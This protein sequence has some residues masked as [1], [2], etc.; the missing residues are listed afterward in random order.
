MYPFQ[1][2][3]MLTKVAVA[4][5]ETV[6]SLPQTFIGRFPFVKMLYYIPESLQLLIFTE[7][8]PLLIKIRTDTE[9]RA[10][11]NRCYER[12]V[13]KQV[14]NIRTPFTRRPTLEQTK[15]PTLPLARGIISPIEGEG[16]GRGGGTGGK[17]GQD[18]RRFAKVF[19]I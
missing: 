19:N 10:Y 1:D 2:T 6:K 18:E 14:K 7:N 11:R 4:I 9:M 12:Y 15:V 13:L 8:I 17:R 3:S 16:G 5:N